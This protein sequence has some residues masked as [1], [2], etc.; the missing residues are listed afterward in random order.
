MDKDNF[1][2]KQTNRELKRRLREVMMAHETE[3]GERERVQESLHMERSELH[4]LNSSLMSEL[5]RR[6]NPI[7]NP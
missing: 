2:Y 3:A 6:R 1:Y 4:A 7:P 5:C